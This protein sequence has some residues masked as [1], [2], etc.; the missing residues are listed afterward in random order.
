MVELWVKLIDFGLLL[1]VK[2][3]KRQTRS[4]IC[5]YTFRRK[6]ALHN[7]FYTEILPPLFGVQKHFLGFRDV[8]LASPQESVGWL[9]IRVESDLRTK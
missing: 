5:G 2:V 8:K 9:C 6:H 3:P 7:I 1:E 4:K